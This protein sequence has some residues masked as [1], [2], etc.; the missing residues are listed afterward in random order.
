MS[1]SFIKFWLHHYVIYTYPCII[2]VYR[3]YKNMYKWRNLVAAIFVSSSFPRA[4][5]PPALWRWLGNPDFLP[6]QKYR[7]N[8]L[9]SENKNIRLSWIIIKSC[10]IVIRS[11]FCSNVLA[12]ILVYA[13]NPPRGNFNIKLSTNIHTKI[14]NLSLR[15]H[16]PPPR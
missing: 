3:W 5:P 11:I 4:P 16:I 8:R 14:N 1:L 9:I 15:G 7:L 13:R 10:L 6:R 12:G 2:N